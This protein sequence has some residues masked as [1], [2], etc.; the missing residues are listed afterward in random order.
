MLFLSAHLF[1][2]GF[3][4]MEINKKKKIPRDLVLDI[5]KTFYD[6]LWLDLL[7]ESKQPPR[8]ISCVNC[9]IVSVSTLQELIFQVDIKND[10]G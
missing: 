9:S 10:H 1:A 8:T 6:Y 4:K 7:E 5:I 2:Q 3:G